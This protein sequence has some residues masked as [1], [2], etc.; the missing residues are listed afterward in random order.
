MNE[1]FGIDMT[2]LT[3]ALVA[4]L[5]VCLLSVGWIAWRRRVVFNLGVRNLPRRKAQTLLIVAGLMLSTL[6]ITSALGVGDTVDRSFTST[7]YSHAGDVDLL[8]LPE[9]KEDGFWNL[10][11]GDVPVEML[12]TVDQ[13]LAANPDVD[14]VMPILAEPVSVSSESTRL[15]EPQVLAIGLD[16]ARIDSFGGIPTTDG[17]SLDF[18]SLA[19][20]SVAISATLAEE[21]DAA[22]GDSIVI[23]VNSQPVGATVAAIVEDSLLTGSEVDG[24]SGLVMPLAD[25]QEITE[26]QE[27]ISAIA[28]STTGGARNAADLADGVGETLQP[29]LDGSGLA[30]NP[31]K[32]AILDEASTSGQIFAGLFLVVGLFSIAAGILLILLIFTM[33]AAER[34]SEMGM[35]RAVGAQRRQLIQQFMSEGAAYSLLAGIAGAALGVAAALGIGFGLSWVFGD[36]I[37]VE[38]YVSARSVIAS[39]ALGVVITFIA[40][41]GSSWRISRLNVVSAVRDLPDAPSRKRT[42]R[43]ILR[44]VLM[45]LIGILMTGIGVSSG[46][47]MPFMTGVSLLILSGALLL[48]ATGISGRRVYSLASLLL[49]LFWLMPE[50]QFSRIFGDYEGDF[51]MFFVSGIFLVVGATILMMQNDQV[52]LNGTS[53]IGNLFRSRLSAFKLAVAYPGSARS[54]TGMTVAMFSLIVFSL[55]TIA[56]LN[57]NFS[58]AFLSDAATAGW[59]IRGSTQQRHVPDDIGAELTASGVDPGEIAAIGELSIPSIDEGNVRPAGDASWQD[60]AV[61]GADASFIE[62]TDWSFSNRASGYD[63]DEAIIEALLTEPGV[64]VVPSWY[65]EGESDFDSDADTLQID[66]DLGVTSFEPAQIELLGSDGQPHTV[67]VIG[68][69]DPKLS[70][71]DRIVGSQQ[72]I[73]QM[74]DT[75]EATVWYFQTTDPERSGDVAREIESALLPFGVQATSIRE[76]L[77]DDQR[78][79]NGFFLILQ[80]FMGLGMLVGVAA[81]GVIASRNVIDRRQQIGVL[82]ALGFQRG[83]VALSFL[84]EAA[85]VVGLGVVSGTFLG[86]ALARNLLTSGEIATTGAIDFAVPW[87]TVS[88]VLALA[89]GAA[90]LMTWLPARQASRIAPAEAL[91]YE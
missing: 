18:S 10:L 74:Y 86:L 71:L 90:L 85:F 3:I 19:Q 39:Y 43:A 48:H 79:N 30:V 78:E 40:V 81:I 42:W 60:A 4:L 41:V 76:M 68:V 62:S 89:V 59:D 35:A 37:D 16:P 38:P 20:G 1:L 2:T 17:N 66:I 27:T 53:R 12:H 15:S 7:A 61:A 88:V 8:I 65:V 29:V 63:S 22:R 31:I 55:V 23:Y 75:Y 6:I 70:G 72:T 84:L 69:I 57:L 87:S 26:K 33:L 21:L 34:R 80:A 5:T 82:R 64:V 14:G 58:N 49:L 44:P 25:L 73:D 11:D 67:T 83:D 13:T 46:S 32:N 50:K 45:V 28:V 54:R 56:T 91:R 77:E 36:F 51:E 47:A 52:L 24:S 9:E